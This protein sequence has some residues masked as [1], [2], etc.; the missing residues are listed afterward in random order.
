MADKDLPKLKQESQKKS[1]FSFDD[2]DDEGFANKSKQS[3]KKED[4]TKKEEKLK[5]LFDDE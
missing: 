3:I 5:F 4:S 1:L 2:N